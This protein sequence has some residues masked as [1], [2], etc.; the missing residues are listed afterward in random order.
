MVLLPT[1]Q[2]VEEVVLEYMDWNPINFEHS[3]ISPGMIDFNIRRTREWEGV[4]TLTKAAIS[5]GVTLCVE[6][7]TMQE[8]DENEAGAL[9]CDLG[10]TMVIE[11][12]IVLA[13]RPEDFSDALGL[14][15][16]LTP[17]ND[18]IGAIHNLE[19][20]FQVANRLGLPLLLDPC[21]AESKVLYMASPCRQLT[22]EQRRCVEDI[23]DVFGGAF[24]DDSVEGSEEENEP[25]SDLRAASKASDYHPRSRT[26]KAP[27]IN[28]SP[29]CKEDTQRKQTLG[30]LTDLR[31]ASFK[32]IHSA[33][34]EEIKKCTDKRESLVSAEM[35]AYRGI[36]QTQ[37]SRTKSMYEIVSEEPT[38]QP[39]VSRG[40][41]KRPTPLN[42]MPAGNLHTPA[43]VYLHQLAYYPD[44]LETKGVKKIIA[45]MKSTPC[46]VHVVNLASAAAVSALHKAR[47]E[48]LEVTCETCPHFL[49]FTDKSIKDGDTRLKNFPPIRNVSNCNFLW[50]LVT[51]NS[52]EAICS[53]HIP[54][55]QTY[56]SSSFRAALPG[57]N[58][59]GYTLQVLWTLLKRPFTDLGSF[60]HYLVRLAR[61]TAYNPAKILQIPNRGSI[62]KG[63]LADLVI[64][65]PLE[66]VTVQQSHSAQSY[67]CAYLNATLY[68]KIE[69]VL[70]RGNLAY[71]EGAFFPIGKT[72]RGSLAKSS[73]A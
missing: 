35:A 4:E 38:D 16:Y 17:P 64:W 9:Y 69:K 19:Q 50:E 12:S 56:K 30:H 48:G 26:T 66:E 1:D 49:Y 33:L 21:V 54:V 14:K 18:T 3:Y 6:E 43:A 29:L 63:Y 36:G 32:D 37:F 42:L 31:S 39:Q 46:K 25:V 47:V 7:K 60:E 72:I 70:I 73:L 58:G 22:L 44:T 41:R 51:M 13:I 40:L 28:T 71:S 2:E 27:N 65:S 11:P 20:W 10:Y 45:A 5:G 15:G 57:I 67:Q 55:P 59:L 52:V 61:W 62:E 23:P 8:S 53:Q 34:M 68:G 24:A